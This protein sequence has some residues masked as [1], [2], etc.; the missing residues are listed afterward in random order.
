VTPHK[1]EKPFEQPSFLRVLKKHCDEK[2][3]VILSRK[4]ILEKDLKSSKSNANQ[5]TI[6]ISPL[7]PQHSPCLSEV[8]KLRAKLNEFN[9]YQVLLGNKKKTIL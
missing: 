3:A 9:Y 7:G 5:K 4:R 1:I 2:S 6:E 8:F